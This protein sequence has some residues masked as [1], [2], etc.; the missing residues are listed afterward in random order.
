MC[1]E[2]NDNDRTRTTPEGPHLQDDP[3]RGKRTSLCLWI[4]SAP[5]LHKHS[6]MME[7]RIIPL[8]EG[9]E[10][11]V[12]RCRTRDATPSVD[13]DGNKCLIKLPHGGS[14]TDNTLSRSRESAHIWLDASV[15]RDKHFVVTVDPEYQTAYDAYQERYNQQTQQLIDSG[16]VGQPMAGGPPQIQLYVNGVLHGRDAGP[17]R[18]DHGSAI[19]SRSR[20]TRVE[21]CHYTE[22]WQSDAT[23]LELVQPAA[24]HLPGVAPA[25]DADAGPPPAIHHKNLLE[26]DSEVQELRDLFKEA[27]IMARRRV[28]VLIIGETG[29]GKEHL[30]RK[31]A[32]W[33]A[34]ARAD[35][36]HQAAPDHARIQVVN[37]ATFGDNNEFMISALFGHTEGAFSGAVRPRRGAVQL[38]AEHDA[39]LFLDEIHFLTPAAQGKLLRLLSDRQVQRLGDDRIV[40]YSPDKMP[41]VIAAAT[42]ALLQ[43]MQA[44]P[45]PGFLPE[46]YQRLTGHLIRLPTLAER[47]ADIQPLTE[48]MLKQIAQLMPGLMEGEGFELTDDALKILKAYDFDGNLRELHKI[49]TRAAAFAMERCAQEKQ[50]VIS[51]V[52]LRLG[53]RTPCPLWEDYGDGGAKTWRE[54]VEHYRDIAAHKEPTVDDNGAHLSPWKIMTARLGAKKCDLNP[55]R[56]ELGQLVTK[57]IKESTEKALVSQLLEIWQDG[58]N[59]LS[60]EQLIAEVLRKPFRFSLLPYDGKSKVSAEQRALLIKEIRGKQPA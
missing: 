18:L 36:S 15:E 16:Q 60:V 50:Y 53:D 27:E 22:A 58:D 34:A 49:L 59:G 24:S 21:I 55:P 6:N 48:V 10:Y 19:A 47:R 39:V 33:R 11:R 23:K 35:Y 20:K 1:R 4:A 31:M 17:V 42:P 41:Y 8:F 3:V 30:A 25:K 26:L 13:W 52:D 54:Y 51:A 40:T 5:R 46:L 43:R 57:A 45:R 38:A 56:R 2:E 29:A 7:D 37:C 28:P 9:A 32:F 44:L 14:E 12:Q